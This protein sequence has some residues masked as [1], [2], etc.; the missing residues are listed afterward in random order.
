MTFK[1]VLELNAMLNVVQNE[2]PVYFNRAEKLV[3]TE[4]SDVVFQ[5]LMW[6]QEE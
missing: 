3:Y 4:I 1:N 5:E 6:I 2:N